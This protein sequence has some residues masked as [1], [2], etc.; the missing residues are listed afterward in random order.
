MVVFAF[1]WNWKFYQ[2][3]DAIRDANAAFSQNNY[4]QA[5]ELMS[6][7]S[8][9]VPEV[10]DVSNLASYFKGI[11]FLAKDKGADALNEFISIKDKLPLN[12]GVERLIW[13]AKI[14]ASFNN[15]NYEGFLEAS[16]GLL[17]L[18]STSAMTWTSVA[19]AYA[20]IYADRGEES[21]QKESLRYLER[22]RTI[23]DSTKEAKSYY[24]MVE[25]RLFSRRIITRDEF[26][27]EFPNGWTNK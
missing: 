2:A 18:D 8:E 5:A 20:C 11:D 10:Q 17:A 25:Y 22:A 16:K 24:N 6:L 9:K 26:A 13:E 12:Y 15:K 7:A 4:S 23:D 21:A 3:Y 1:G 19:S 14:G 27:K